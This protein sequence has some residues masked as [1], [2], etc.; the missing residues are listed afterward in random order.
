MEIGPFLA[1]ATVF[2]TNAEAASAALRSTKSN[3]FKLSHYQVLEALENARSWS[4]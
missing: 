1:I 2:P 4:D 3:K